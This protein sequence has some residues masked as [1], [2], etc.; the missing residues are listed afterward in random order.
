M[1]VR[2][3]QFGST[4]IPRETAA[5]PGSCKVFPLGVVRVPPP[6]PFWQLVGN[7]VECT[8]IG[9]GNVAARRRASM[10]RW[11][12][13]SPARGPCQAVSLDRLVCHLTVSFE[14]APRRDT[15]TQSQTSLSH[16][17]SLLGVQRPSSRWCAAPCRCQVASGSR[18]VTAHARLLRPDRA[19]VAWLLERR[20]E[21]SRPRLPRPPG[22][23]S[24]ASQ[25]LQSWS[26]RGSSS[27]ARGGFRPRDRARPGRQRQRSRGRAAPGA[28]TRLFCE[29]RL[30]CT[31]RPRPSALLP[32]RRP[33]RLES[34]RWR[35][36]SPASSAPPRE[37]HHASVSPRVR[38]A[39]ER[40]PPLPPPPPPRRR[41]RPPGSPRPRPPRPPRRPRP[42]PTPRS[43]KW[44]V[45]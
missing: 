43:V 21:P 16:G 35:P 2:I 28:P 12:I 18:L 44:S 5:G 45:T 9:C 41:G 4:A 42:P 11:G 3:G 20:N 30:L 33:S 31:T 6:A 13:Q 15:Q 40:P 14:P 25:R 37:C 29:P 34:T 32:T 23:P 22:P 10:P 7:S 1:F 36:R 27:S 38:E 39:E 8:P 26:W 17:Q 19:Q 24:T